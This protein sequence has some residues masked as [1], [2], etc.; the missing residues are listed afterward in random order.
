MEIRGLDADVDAAS[1]A[2]DA[3]TD[4]GGVVPT[5]TGPPACAQLTVRFVPTPRAQ[6]AVWISRADGRFA[7]LA[8]TEA[9]A[10]RGIGNRPGAMQMNSGYR[11]PMGRRESVL[12][13]WAGERLASG[14][15]PFRRVVFQNRASEGDA[16]RTSANDS[17]YDAYF[18]LSFNVQDTLRDHLDA[19]SCASFFSGDRGRYITEADVAAGYAE[20]FETAPG[21]GTM[22]TLS[23]TSAYPPR[24]D[25]TRS[26]NDS[27]DVAQFA[28][29]ALAAM[30]E[31]DAV[32]VASLRWEPEVVIDWTVP[33]D[34]GDAPIRVSVEVN[35]EGDYDASYDPTSYPT[36][37]AP[38]G[39]WDV[40]SQQ[41]GYP[42]RGQPSVVF[43][44]EPTCSTEIAI[45]GPSRRG[46]VD[47][48]LGAM[49]MDATIVDDPG[50]APGS[51]ADR[52]T[53]Q[54]DG[55]RLHVLL[56]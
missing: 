31:L 21:V 48:T 9:T 22:R 38:A 42:Y 10:Y 24:R 7:T 51:G 47:G 41:Y 13:V 23:L 30:P 1:T 8:L 50:A 4:A 17:S 33:A 6:F 54:A 32:T 55:A 49:P 45:T 40:Y 36:P 14:A 46:N 2:V 44:A 28:T 56:R 52:L 15:A 26:A 5:D 19:V 18:C 20:P 43:D 16:D 27:P 34:W 53:R 39:A 11:W 35:T 29:D 12:P 37:I 3:G 25:V